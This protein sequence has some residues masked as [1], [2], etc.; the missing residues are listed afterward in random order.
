MSHPGPDFSY[1][2][3]NRSELSNEH[4]KSE[5]ALDALEISSQLSLLS[6]HKS[7]AG[8]KYSHFIVALHTVDIVISVALRLLLLRSFRLA[9]LRP[10]AYRRF[11]LRVHRPSFLSF[12]LRPDYRALRRHILS[13]PPNCANATNCDEST[14]DSYLYSGRIPSFGPNDL[15]KK[16]PLAPAPCPTMTKI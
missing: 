5:S 15:A 12:S 9:V 4:I 6:L 14:L 2:G 10:G 11:Q 1:I 3:G 7:F 13:F 8:R 16:I